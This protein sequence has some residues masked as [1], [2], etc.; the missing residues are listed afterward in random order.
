GKSGR[1]HKKKRVCIL[2]HPHGSASGNVECGSRFV[3]LCRWI[4][5]FLCGDVSGGKLKNIKTKK[6]RQSSDYQCFLP[7]GVTG[8]EPATTRPPG[9]YFMIYVFCICLI[10]SM[11]FIDNQLFNFYKFS[12]VLMVFA[13]NV[14]D[15]L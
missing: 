12:S 10:F 7:V 3:S 1:C 11:V 6:H 8:F 4:L 9:V 2:T 15:L 14:V 13:Q 5:L